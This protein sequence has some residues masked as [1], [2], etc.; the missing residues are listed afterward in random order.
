VL[1]DVLDH[2]TFPEEV[3]AKIEQ[4]R[5]LFADWSRP[6][7]EGPHRFS[8][9]E[10]D[11]AY[12]ELCE[13]LRA[14]SIRGWHCTRLTEDEISRVATLGLKPLNVVFLQERID[15]AASAG[16]IPAGIAERLR[17]THQAN[18]SN[19]AGRIWFCLHLPREAGEDG[20]RRL[21]G[22]W[23][24]EA[25]YNSHE[26]DAEV[27]SILRSLGKPCVVEA[28]LPIPSLNSAWRVATAL[29][30]SDLIMRGV[31]TDLPHGPED[32]ATQCIEPPGLRRVVEL[33]HA[34]FE[35][36]VGCGSWTSPLR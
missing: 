23:G 35:A 8:A 19:R 18:E 15:S 22:T 3:S 25:L 9:R 32:F 1:L 21:L 36:L 24:G 7:P 16:L 11:A 33:A 20:L 26:E 2:S 30:R 28:D 5:E 31:P 13:A 29:V 12:G 4:H 34:D 10:H 17:T 27:L 6:G 14:H